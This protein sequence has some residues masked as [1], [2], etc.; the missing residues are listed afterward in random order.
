MTFNPVNAILHIANTYLYPNFQSNIVLLISDNNQ[1]ETHCGKC[2]NLFVCS[3]E[4]I[5]RCHCSN[6]RLS[7][8]T[9]AFLSETYFD[10]LCN[11]CLKKV[12][13]QVTISQQYQFPTQRADFQE[14]VHYY[15]EGSY[16]VFTELYHMLRGQCC[17]SGCRHCVYGY[18]K[19][20]G[21]ENTKSGKN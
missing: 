20:S 5:S 3:A 13:E 17:Q 2:N 19:K 16:W 21:S 8:E 18:S 4:D 1:M 15:I 7:A 14:G 11:D 10:C 6:V 9:T 12:D